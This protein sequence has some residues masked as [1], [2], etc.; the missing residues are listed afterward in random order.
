MFFYAAVSRRSIYERL[1]LFAILSLFTAHIIMVFIYSGDTAVFLEADRAS[2]RFKKILDL[3]SASSREE[4]VDVMLRHGNPGD[5]VVQ[6]LI[7]SLFGSDGVVLFQIALQALSICILWKLAKGY[8][9]E[10][11]LFLSIFAYLL[12]PGTIYRPHVLASES[13]FVPLAIV[14]FY[15]MLTAIRQESR[16]HACHRSRLWGGVACAIAAEVRNV[17][18]LFPPIFVLLHG[19]RAR[20]GGRALLCQLVFVGLSL[21]LVVGWIV[22]ASVETGRFAFA[23]SGHDLGRN[24][25]IRAERM[26]DIGGY[27]LRASL[28][29]DADRLSPAEFVS[30]VAAH[31]TSYLATLRSDS[32]NLVLNSGVNTVYGRF[33]GL[34]DTLQRD[35]LKRWRRI[36]DAQ[37]WAEMVKIMIHERP[38]LFLLNLAGVFLWCIFSA[39]SLVGLVSLL[40]TPELS[41]TERAFFLLFLLFGALTPFLA[42]SVRWD[43]RTPIE[44]LLAILFGLGCVTL[45]KAVMPARKPR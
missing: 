26:A 7:Y 40:R 6:G 19:A 32:V 8:F 11:V 34:F 42:G 15:F 39:I 4:L 9:S 31:P 27:S 18:V 24:L 43:H 12:L 33:F 16:G 25:F 35:D 2:G 1:A 14:A 44:F 28:G 20:T 38:Q 5:F 37:G 17:F 3:S 30:H 10:R 23:R 36:R 29:D 45:R 21:S 22:F 13:L 41:G